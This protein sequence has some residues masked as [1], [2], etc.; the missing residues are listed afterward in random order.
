MQFMLLF[1]A[2][3]HRLLQVDLHVPVNQMTAAGL[4]S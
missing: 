4:H 3:V 1:N 2:F